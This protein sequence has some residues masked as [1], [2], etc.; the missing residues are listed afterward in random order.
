MSRWIAAGVVLLVIVGIAGCGDSTPPARTAPE[1][2]PE[3]I[4]TA[5]PVEEAAEGVSEPVSPAP[6]DADGTRDLA[7]LSVKVGADGSITVS[8]EDRWGEKL[9]TTYENLEFLTNALPVLKR[10]ITEEQG[11]AL[12][13]AGAAVAGNEP[14]P[15]EQRNEL[16][17]REMCNLRNG[18]FINGPQNAL[19]PRIVIGMQGNGAPGSD[20]A[21][22]QA[23]GVLTFL[24]VRPP[25]G[26]EQVDDLRLP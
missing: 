24:L 17:A 18:C 6:T 12:D 15:P 3:M 1:E 7:G 16:L 8:G 9:D 19:A 26:V 10:T 20:A 23:C 11:R 4:E 14:D 25:G 22:Q 2:E 21:L 5:P 13:Q